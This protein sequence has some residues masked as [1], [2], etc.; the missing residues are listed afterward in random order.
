MRLLRHLQHWLSG[1]GVPLQ[2]ADFVPD[3]H[4]MRQW[5]NTFPWTALVAAIEHSFVTR[6]PTRSPAWTSPDAD[7]GIVGPGATQT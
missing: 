5:A 3:T 6:F 1:T 7:P 4:P 2:V